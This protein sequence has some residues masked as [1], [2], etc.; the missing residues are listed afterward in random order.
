[1]NPRLIKNLTHRQRN[2]KDNKQRYTPRAMNTDR[3]N[4]NYFRR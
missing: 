3:I 2:G 4:R 1:M